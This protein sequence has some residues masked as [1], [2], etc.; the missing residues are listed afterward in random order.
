MVYGLVGIFIR[1]FVDYIAMTFRSRKLILY[2]AVIIGI[3]SFIP[4]SIQQT[5]LT[6]TIQSI[7]VGVGANMIWT[8]EL[9]FKE[10]YTKNRSFLTVLIMAFP[11]LIADFIAAP[12]QSIIKVYAVSQANN[13]TF[14]LS[15]M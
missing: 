7:G 3:I 15:L 13:Y 10:Q 8:Y 12:V 5:T 2:S 1:P 4:I 14:I 11:P 9:M 6:N